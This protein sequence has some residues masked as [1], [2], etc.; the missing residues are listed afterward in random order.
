MHF[1]KKLVYSIILLPKRLQSPEPCEA[2]WRIT[3][4][5]LWSWKNGSWDEENAPS[6]K[7]ISQVLSFFPFSRSFFLSL[8]LYLP[9]FLPISLCLSYLWCSVSLKDAYRRGVR[10][11]DL[12]PSPH[13]REKKLCYKSTITTKEPIIPFIVS[14]V[15]GASY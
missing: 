7:L 3:S 15:V 9:F 2:F 4:T 8:S 6:N 1:L 13:P 10:G 5:L 14:L 11:Y 12:G